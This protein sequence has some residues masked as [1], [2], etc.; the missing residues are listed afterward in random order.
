MAV[1]RLLYICTVCAGVLGASF[2]EAFAAADECTADPTCDLSLRQ[3]RG[4]PQVSSDGTSQRAFSASLLQAKVKGLKKRDACGASPQLHGDD[5]ESLISTTKGVLLVAVPE[6]RCTQAA[7][8]ALQGKG[9]PYTMK[10]FS[11]EFTYTK[12]G[13]SVWD[14]LHCKYPQDD[15]D[16]TTMHSY[17]FKDG[18]FLGQGFAAAT[19]VES[20]RLGGG[21][22]EGQSC[23]ERFSEDADVVSKYMSNATNRVLLFG[24]INCP[25][26]GIAQSRF[27]ADSVCYVGR[28]WANPGSSLM[29]YLQCKES[30]D[31]SHSFIYFRKSTAENSDWVFEGN[32]FAFEDKAMT[33]SELSAKVQASGAATSCKRA[34]VKTNLYGTQLEECRVGNDDMGSWMDDGT[35]S[36]QTGGI[37]QICIESLPADFSSETHQTAWS[38]ERAGQRHCV[39]VG[40]W[41]LYMTDAEKHKEGAQNIMPH[42]RSIPET[43]LTAEYLGHWK[44]W[45]GYPASVLNGIGELVERC[46]GQAQTDKDKCGLKARFKKLQ[47]SKEAAGLKNANEL[48]SLTSSLDALSCQ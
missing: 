2:Q 15:Q 43:V 28:Q 23:E 26:V 3:L 21:R 13:S 37:H 38:K 17:V 18:A 48:K 39:C 4:E 1:A 8:N 10:E 40:A 42:C 46:L 20:G 31:T 6:M 7:L 24:W 44:D 5:L 22:A 30:D 11:G 12:G 34:N 16:G 36:E 9:I 35:C 45:N 33:S 19:V 29:A 14:W 32:G 41:S 25:C 47:A 27:A